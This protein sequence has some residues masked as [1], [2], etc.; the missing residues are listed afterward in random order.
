[1]GSC[2]YI[3]EEEVTAL[4]GSNNRA[5]Q[6]AEENKIMATSR[7]YSTAYCDKDVYRLR[8]IFTD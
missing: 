5:S 6:G 7:D 4:I 3:F 8:M 2:G 1:V